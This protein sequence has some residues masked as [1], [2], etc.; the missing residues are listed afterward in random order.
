MLRA[1][2][3]ATICDCRFIST[4]VWTPLKSECKAENVNAALLDFLGISEVPQ[5]PKLRRI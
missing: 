3:L 5:K 1:V 2:K 4:E